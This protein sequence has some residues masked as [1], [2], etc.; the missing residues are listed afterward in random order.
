LL[1]QSTPA[2]STIGFAGRLANHALHADGRLADAILPP[3]KAAFWASDSLA[4]LVTLK[5][6][7]IIAQGKRT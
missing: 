4:A 3:V 1:W 7:N 2:H 5:A 6:F